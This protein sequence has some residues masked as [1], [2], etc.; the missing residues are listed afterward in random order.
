MSSVSRSIIIAS[1]SRMEHQLPAS[2]SDDARGG[3]SPAPIA[4]SSARWQT[5][6]GSGGSAT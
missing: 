6:S 5:R 3:C 1:R 2:S 4:L